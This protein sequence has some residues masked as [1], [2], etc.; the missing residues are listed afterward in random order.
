MHTGQATKPLPGRSL[1]LAA[2]KVGASPCVRRSL[3]G[4][5]YCLGGWAL[6]QLRR[7]GG[8]AEPPIQELKQHKAFWNGH[9]EKNLYLLSRRIMRDLLSQQSWLP[10]RVHLI[11]KIQF[12]R[13]SEKTNKM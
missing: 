10:A 5:G 9:K 2:S 6:L 8:D 3:P 11:G 4:A 7:R 13:A 1:W 12:Q